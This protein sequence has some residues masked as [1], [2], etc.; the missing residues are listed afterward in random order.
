MIRLL[1][2]FAVLSTSACGMGL[3][4]DTHSTVGLTITPRDLRGGFGTDGHRLKMRVKL[5]GAT[6][7]IRRDFYEQLLNEMVAVDLATRTPLEFS[8]EEYEPDRDHDYFSVVIDDAR[9]WTFFGFSSTL[10][11]H[12]NLYEFEGVG[13]GVRVHPDRVLTLRGGRACETEGGMRVVVVLSNSTSTRLD[14]F[15]QFHL[16]QCRRVERPAE[17][18]DTVEFRCDYVERTIELTVIGKGDAFKML[19]GSS[20]HFSSVRLS[21]RDRDGAGC[22]NFKF[23]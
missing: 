1:C 18:D 5:T 7:A 21:P 13:R 15:E 3:H 11:A 4:D 6:E 12:Q 23:Q 10:G 2:T 14:D 16:A 19:D 20:R 17:I 22:W 8:L 9:D